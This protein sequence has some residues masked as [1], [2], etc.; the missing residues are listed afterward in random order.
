M[1][2]RNPENYCHII[3]AVGIFP[4]QSTPGFYI[5]WKPMGNL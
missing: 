4:R 5:I 3:G 2:E 1:W